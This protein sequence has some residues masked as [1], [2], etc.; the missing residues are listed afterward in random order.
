MAGGAVLVQV[1]DV[2]LH[3]QTSSALKHSVKVPLA[4]FRKTF[5][6][7]MSLSLVPYVVSELPM[8]TLH[9]LTE[10]VWCITIVNQ[11]A[12][13]PC[14]SHSDLHTFQA[15]LYAL[16]GYEGRAADRHLL[17]TEQFTLLLVTRTVQP[18]R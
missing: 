18:G 13:S 16:T 6:L 14:A 11:A 1:P 12:L 9:A 10:A 5:P 2:M 17:S 3:P 4:T 15:T 8:F 7:Y